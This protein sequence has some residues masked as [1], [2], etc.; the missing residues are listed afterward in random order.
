MAEEAVV[1]DETRWVRIKRSAAARLTNCA[2]VL[3]TPFACTLYILYRARNDSGSPAVALVGGGVL[4]VV[5]GLL[6]WWDRAANVYHLRGSTLRVRGRGSGVI[7]LAQVRAATVDRDSN[8]KIMPTDGVR[9][10]LVDDS[11]NTVTVKIGDRWVGR[12]LRTDGLAAI[13]EQLDQPSAPE[14]VQRIAEWLRDYAYR[15]GAEHWPD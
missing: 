7:D 10:N 4:G 5:F 8:R 6:F 12:E 9:L 1:T 13:A 14:P 3:L 2:A 15:P 11:Y